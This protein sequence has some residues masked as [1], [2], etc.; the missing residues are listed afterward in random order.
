MSSC[1][2]IL[3]Y[4]APRTCQDGDSCCAVRIMEVTESLYYDKIYDI[5]ILC[6]VL[7][8]MIYY[9]MSRG[10]HDNDASDQET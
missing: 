5:N 6:K 3:E 4:M 9:M 7:R 10:I 1:K 8:T 2:I